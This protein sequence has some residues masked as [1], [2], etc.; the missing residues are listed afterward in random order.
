LTLKYT[1]CFCR[2][3]GRLLMLLRRKQPHAG[4]WNGVG[5]KI[6][7]FESPR[8]C[9]V[10]EVREETALDLAT[11]AELRFG[12]IVTWPPDEAVNGQGAGM[13]VYVAEFR[14]PA[15]T[16]SGD[17]LVVDGM[18][19]WQRQEWVCD[20][21]NRQ[22]VAN[23]PAFLRPMLRG[24]PPREYYCDF[25]GETLLSVRAGRLLP[26]AVEHEIEGCPPHPKAP[27]AV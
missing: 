3:A 17:R 12:G 15:V 1:L 22:V 6:E 14:D 2:C 4:E 13:Y 10:R 23:I 24:E 18:L 9:I 16:W 25:Q 20:G 19:R 5:G 8:A 27:L 11:A 7:P 26:A 21:T